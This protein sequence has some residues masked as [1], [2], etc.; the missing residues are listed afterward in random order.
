MLKTHNNATRCGIIWQTTLPGFM[1]I[2]FIQ[3]NRSKLID[4]EGQERIGMRPKHFGNKKQAKKTKSSKNLLKAC[5]KK[6]TDI[7]IQT[8]DVRTQPNESFNASSTKVLPKN[9]TFNTSNEARWAVAVGRN[10][11]DHFDSQI[12]EMFCPGCISPQV[13]DEIKKDEIEWKNECI[14]RNTPS[15]RKRKNDARQ[16]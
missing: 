4:V 3:M 9:A 16:K 13:M 15:E 12:Q 10:N 6:T 14:R 1:T 5:L 8:G 11:N 2:A 7:V